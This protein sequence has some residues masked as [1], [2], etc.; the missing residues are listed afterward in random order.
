MTTIQNIENGRVK[1]LFI[2]DFDGFLADLVGRLLLG[3]LERI[4]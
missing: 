4:Q 1:A 2:M 3:I